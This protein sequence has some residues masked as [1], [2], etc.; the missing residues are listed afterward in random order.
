MTADEL[1]VVDG[2]IS[3]VLP[4][5]TILATIISESGGYRDASA[6]ENDRFETVISISGAYD[7]RRGW[8]GEEFAERACRTMD[9]SGRLWEN[10]RRRQDTRV[11]NA[12]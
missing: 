1:V 11:G 12:H 3:L 5:G 10:Y 4:V 7:A 9:S 6:S 2:S 8:C